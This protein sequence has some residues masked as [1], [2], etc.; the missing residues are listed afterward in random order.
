MSK[1]IIVEDYNPQ[2]KDWFESIKGTLIRTLNGLVLDIIHVGSTSIIGLKSKPIID[3]DIV[4]YKSEFQ[5][6]IEKLHEIGYIHI[7][8]LGIADREA[9]QRENIEL[10]L[11]LPNHH[12]YLCFPGSKG[13]ENH[14]FLKE[15]LNL[16]PKTVQEYG[17]LK[18]RLAKEYPHDID[19]YMNGKSYFIE[20]VITNAKNE[21]KL[22]KLY[23]FHRKY[24]RKF[25]KD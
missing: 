2:W 13:L 25:K 17:L 5:I 9:F 23:T 12:L 22:D 7:G 15:Y 18:E 4:A 8:N 14:L 3:I 6:V 10:Q 24:P 11:N 20:S 1:T 19:G 21:I 16:H